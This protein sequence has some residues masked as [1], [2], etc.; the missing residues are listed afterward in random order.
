MLTFLIIALFIIAAWAIK[1]YNKLQASKQDIIE[2]ASNMQISLQKRKDLASRILDIAQ[3]FGDHEKITHLKI[4]SNQQASIEKLSALGQNFPELKANET[5]IQLMRQLEDLEDNISNKREA[6]N[7][8]VKHYNSFRSSFPT[9]FIAQKMNFE[10]A[11]YYDAGNEDMLNTLATFSRDDAAA[12]QQLISNTSSSLVKSATELKESASKQIEQ[13]KKSDA[14]K[15]VVAKSD[16]A[17]NK[18][19]DIMKPKGTDKPDSN[20]DAEGKS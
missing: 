8:S 1:T 3:G 9:L 17:I 6:Y 20:D 13:V 2:Q 19:V 14:V 18:A 12:V 11:P 10:I 15:A 16:I 7:S 4:S 5:Y